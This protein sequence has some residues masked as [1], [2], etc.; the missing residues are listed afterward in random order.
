[1]KAGRL[2]C[3][4]NGPVSCR[5]CEVLVG[6]G[7]FLGS[8]TSILHPN[9]HPTPS[10]TSFQASSHTTLHNP[11]YTPSQDRVDET[12]EGGGGI[13]A[14]WVC[15]L[16]LPIS[17]SGLFRGDGRGRIVSP[18]TIAA[19]CP[20]GVH[21]KSEDKPPSASPPFVEVEDALASP[22]NTIGATFSPSKAIMPPQS[23]ALTPRAL[24][25]L[26]LRQTLLTSATVRR[27]PD[28]GY[29]PAKC[30]TSS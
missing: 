11:S 30:G 20:H 4:S 23:L 26:S 15:Q 16:A 9:P 5:L 1:M 22:R 3:C 24:K 10:Y 8:C 6:S 25:P 12:G 13:K 2:P 7:R 29:I 19:F 18:T 28:N 17:R 27:I 14:E 21:S